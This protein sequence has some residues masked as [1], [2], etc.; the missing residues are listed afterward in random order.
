M[1]LKYDPKGTFVMPTY[2]LLAL[3]QQL[4]YPLGYRDR[5]I[6]EDETFTRAKMLEHLGNLNVPDHSG[7][8][9]FMETLIALSNNYAGVPLPV[10][11]TTNKMARRAAAASS[12]KKLPAAEHNA[13]SSYLISLLQSRLR[14]YN[15]RIAP[16]PPEPAVAVRAKGPPQSPGSAW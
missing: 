7:N 5:P 9:H 3:L 8:I 12:L 11:D 2:N 14:S 10:C 13:L 4:S 15:G 16:Q 1:W 6:D